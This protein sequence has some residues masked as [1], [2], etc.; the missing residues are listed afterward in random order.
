MPAPQSLERQLLLGY[1]LPIVCLGVIM[2]LT[3]SAFRAS[4]QGTALISHTSD[5]L[6]Q[7]QRLE[8]QEDRAVIAYQQALI[9]WDVE[10]QRAYQ[11]AR[12]EFHRLWLAV[13]ANVGDN[14]VQQARLRAW[15]NHFRTWDETVV[16]P[17]LRTSGTN[18]LPSPPDLRP[19]RANEAIARALHQTQE[20]LLEQQWTAAQHSTRVAYWAVLLG[21]PLAA[22]LTWRLGHNL[23]RRIRQGT[24]PLILAAERVMEGDLSARVPVNGNDELTR[25]SRRFNM[26]ASRLQNV[27]SEQRELQHTLEQRVERLVQDTTREIQLLGQ[28]GTFM[29]ACHD[30][31]EAYDVICHTAE[32]L[33]PGGGEIAL[34]SA[35]RNLLTVQL[36]WGF[37]L[38]GPEVFGPED[39]WALRLGQPHAAHA[40][41]SRPHCQHD[42]SGQPTLCVP[43]IA[44]GDTLGVVTL[45]FET[46]EALELARPLAQRFAERVALSLVNLRLRATLRQQSIRDPLTGLYNR[47]YLEETFTRE[48]A[49][50][51]RRRQPLSLLMIDV[52]HFKQHNDTYGHALGDTLLRRLATHLQR[53]FRTEDIVCR[54]G[55]EEFVVLLPECDAPQAQ[56]RAEALRRSVE[57][58]AVTSNDAEFVALTISIGGASWPDH[59]TTPEDLL[60]R[61]DAA[62]YRAKHNG[63]NRVEFEPIPGAA[64]L[65][66]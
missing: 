22:L 44:Q 59:A 30:E 57:N 65:P 39:C 36:Q 48:L 55:G 1:V 9:S 13:Y 35:S 56:A 7:L 43:L 42:T 34:L 33:F 6:A 4:Q 28:L 61:A 58:L 50:V 38:P 60:A 5:V 21:L 19:L 40:G 12:E 47:R 17:T 53:F 18:G 20:Q 46:G 14:P 25:L 26:M 2:V 52:D 29:Q 32:A 54:Y 8:R 45:H 41:L 11:E 64:G 51:Q 62:L 10:D 3:L 66:D 24:Q 63:R 15:D 16:Q 23:L 31:S 37:A 49:R 27:V